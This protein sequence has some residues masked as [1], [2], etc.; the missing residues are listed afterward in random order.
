MCAAL[1]PMRIGKFL[2]TPGGLI[3]LACCSRWCSSPL[4]LT[5]MSESQHPPS[6]QCDSPSVVARAGMWGR[7]DERCMPWNPSLLDP[8]V[9]VFSHCGIVFSCHSTLENHL[10][11]LLAQLIPAHPPDFRRLWCQATEYRSQMF[12]TAFYLS[13][14]TL[15]IRLQDP[16]HNKTPYRL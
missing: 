16:F 6:E 8:N 12:C 14:T 4:T 9:W 2:S 11:G 5:H 3:L 7:M 10:S 1:C 13:V 15:G